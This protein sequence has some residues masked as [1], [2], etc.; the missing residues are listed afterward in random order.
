M[1]KI[2]LSL[3]VCGSI[4]SVSAQEDSTTK[5][6]VTTTT[7]AT[8]HKYSYYPSSDVYF[9]QLTGNYWYHDKGSTTWMMTKTLPST[10]IVEKTAPQFPI[11]Y[12]GDDPW[13][14]NGTD[15]KKY[16]MKKNGTV[17]VKMK[18]KDD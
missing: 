3:L 9:D 11:T 1:K 4:L 6:T 7:T 17:K 10:I 8:P 14:N 2:L 12:T 16:K 5:T 15:V 13:K 18:D